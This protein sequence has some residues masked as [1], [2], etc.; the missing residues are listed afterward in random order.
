LRRSAHF[1]RRLL[2]GHVF[3]PREGSK[4]E[5]QTDYRCSDQHRPYPEQPRVVRN[6]RGDVADYQPFDLIV[7]QNVRPAILVRESAHRQHPLNRWPVLWAPRKR[8]D[9][10]E[11]CA[12]GGRDE[13]HMLPL[14]RNVY[15]CECARTRENAP[16]KRVKAARCRSL[17]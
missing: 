17:H 11:G 16:N 15:R 6:R 5:E 3:V 1:G 12:H 2:R 9:H 7:L 4:T 8:G 14:T 10:A 13:R